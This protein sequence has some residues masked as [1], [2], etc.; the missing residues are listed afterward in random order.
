RGI[1]RYD[2]ENCTD[3][4]ELIERRCVQKPPHHLLI[5]LFKNFP[6]LAKLWSL[7][8]S[9]WRDHIAELLLRFSADRVAVSRTFF[10]ARPVDKILNI[11]PGLSDPHNKGRSVMLLQCHA[12][13]IIYKPRS[14][15]GEQ[16]W[17]SFIRY[18]NAGSFR[19]KLKA[20]RVLCR[21]GYCWMEKFK[22][23]PSK[24]RQP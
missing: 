3:T 14:G 19:P 5:S 4:R 22:C 20:A 7:L 9:Q 23:R 1:E 16:E 17:F 24:Y 2:S 11:R 21:D 6:V 8:I 15:H 10:A 13:S 12:S 18:L